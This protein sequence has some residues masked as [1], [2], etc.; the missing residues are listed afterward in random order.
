MGKK[1]TLLPVALLIISLSTLTGCS[2]T[3][4]A[5]H[6][7]D[8]RTIISD[9]KPQRSDTGL[10]GYTDPNGTKLQINKNEVKELSEVRN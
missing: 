4:Y 9:G 5:I 8:G 10:L 3:S 7:T 6:T 1:T 2:H